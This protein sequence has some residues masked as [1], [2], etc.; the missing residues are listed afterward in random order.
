MARC[1]K[2]CVVL[3]VLV[4][5]TAMAMSHH[6]RRRTSFS[7]RVLPR[8]GVCVDNERTYSEC[9]LC[10]KIVADYR[11]Y[12]GCCRQNALILNFCRHL[13]S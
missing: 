12:R 4:V 11:I 10:G 13:L 3:L 1:C 7:S 9:Y 6:G 8:P 5:S 2:C